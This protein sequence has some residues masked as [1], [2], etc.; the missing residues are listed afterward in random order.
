MV[1]LWIDSQSCLPQRVG[2]PGSRLILWRLDGIS[3]SPIAEWR[4]R[5]SV[6]DYT[7]VENALFRIGMEAGRCGLPINRNELYRQ[8]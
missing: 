6:H 7:L 3:I 4:E 2:L 1:V 5:V 8:Q